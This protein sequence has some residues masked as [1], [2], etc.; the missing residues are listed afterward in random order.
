MLKKRLTW[1]ATFAALKNLLTSTVLFYN[2]KFG[3][4]RKKEVNRSSMFP[5]S[6]QLLRHMI[7]YNGD[8]KIILSNK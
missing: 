2:L 7:D 1:K 6:K 5:I 4:Q 8:F 3:S